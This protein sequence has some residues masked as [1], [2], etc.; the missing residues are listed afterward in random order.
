MPFSPWL[1]D[2][3]GDCP[4]D[5]PPGLGWADKVAV[6]DD[7]PGCRA[8]QSQVGKWK[9]GQKKCRGSRFGSRE[10]DEGDQHQGQQTEEVHPGGWVVWVPTPG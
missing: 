9:V 1:Q 7:G 3:V 2:T 8:Q 5:T 10:M 6:S 4:P